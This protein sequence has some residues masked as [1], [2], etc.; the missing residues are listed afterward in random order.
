LDLLGLE[1]YLLRP[2]LCFEKNSFS[3]SIDLKDLQLLFLD[4]RETHVRF[5]PVRAALRHPSVSLLSRL[6]IAAFLSN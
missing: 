2:L 5:I 1:V 3:S 6:P 4:H